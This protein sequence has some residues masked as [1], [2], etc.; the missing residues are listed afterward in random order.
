MPEARAGKWLDAEDNQDRDEC[1]DPKIDDR[2]TDGTKSPDPKI[3]DRLTHGTT[4]HNQVNAPGSPGL[5][6]RMQPQN[7]LARFNV[8]GERNLRHLCRRYG[9]AA[10]W[11]QAALRFD[12][13]LLS[14]N[15]KEPG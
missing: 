7:T 8:F 10:G 3:D 1:P 11:M 15:T 4:P 13:V 2:F 12:S 9:V 6:E 5:P 14:G